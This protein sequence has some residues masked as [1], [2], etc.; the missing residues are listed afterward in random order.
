MADRLDSWPMG[1]PDPEII[2][3]MVE[4]SSEA[5]WIVDFQTNRKFWLASAGNREKYGLPSGDADSDFWLKNIH[6]DD[7]KKAVEGFRSAQKNQS[8][9]LYEHEYRFLVGKGEVYMINDSMRFFRDASGKVIRV[10]GV[11]KD[12][13]ENYFREE[14]LQSLLTSVEEDLDRF[15]I[16]S[17]ISNATM[18]EM[19]LV[20]DR[21][22]W[23]AGNRTL[24]EFG[25]TKSNYSLNDWASCICEEDRKR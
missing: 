19:D 9:R 25:L 7:V 4:I 15:R 13:T 6:P 14:K 17:G 22:V 10:V 18:W 21:V 24:E 8:M 23:K 1:I 11:W 3:A 5:V 16:I 2:E 20:S 12:V